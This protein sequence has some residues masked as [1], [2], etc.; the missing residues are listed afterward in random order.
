MANGLGAGGAGLTIQARDASNWWSSAAQRWQKTASVLKRNASQESDEGLAQS[1]AGDAGATEIEDEDDEE[2]EDEDGDGEDDEV[3]DR[4]EAIG[5]MSDGG[6]PSLKQRKR[7][8]V[9]E[10]ALRPQEPDKEEQTS[11]EHSANPGELIGVAASSSSSSSAPASATAQPAVSPEPKFAGLKIPV[12]P[13]TASPRGMRLNSVEELCGICCNEV[14]PCRAVRLA[15]SHGWYCARCVQL[16]AEARLATGA[17]SITCP[18]CCTALAERDLRKL[19]PQDLI[20]RLLSRSLEQAVSSAADLWACPTPNCPMRV[21]LEDG[22]LPRLKCT[23]C[24]KTSCLRCGMQPWH[25][26]LTCEQAQQRRTAGKRKRDEGF[27]SLMKWIEETGTKQCPTC[28]MAVTKQKLEN[29]GTQYS[30]CHKMCCRNCG[31]KFCFKCLA[32]LSEN[33]T[34]GCTINAHG[35]IDPHTGKR[36]NHM[37]NGAGKAKG[38]AAAKRTAASRR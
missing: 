34:C 23:V 6:M 20:D 28:R 35:F 3:A 26:G 1:S 22:E 10:Q 12:T 2:D 18:E 25:R 14:P 36:V 15:C 29:Q 38:K 27:Q 24:N 4:E 19:L 13:N 31:T 16:H 21:A 9:Q 37:R 33:F 17:S 30:E 7:E 32:V 11:L 8:V 5:G